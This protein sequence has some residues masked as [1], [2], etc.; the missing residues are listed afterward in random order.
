M[1]GKEITLV[2]ELHQSEQDGY[3]TYRMVARDDEGPSGNYYN[4]TLIHDTRSV[5]NT[6]VNELSGDILATKLDNARV[7]ITI[8]VSDAA[9]T[10]SMKIPR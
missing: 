9:Q 2:G 5:A 8:D 3:R 6:R 10:F 1:I 4:L 7:T